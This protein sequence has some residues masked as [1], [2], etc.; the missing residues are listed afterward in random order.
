LGGRLTPESCAIA[1][2]SGYLAMVDG[3]IYGFG[4]T[5]AMGFSKPVA[6]HPAATAMIFTYSCAL[7]FPNL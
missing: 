7:I 1:V 2:I 4:V 6:L 3:K 5:E